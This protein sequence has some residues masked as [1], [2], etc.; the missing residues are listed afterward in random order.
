MEM[1]Y[2][3]RCGDALKA[4]RE[5][6]Y[7]GYLNEVLCFCEKENRWLSDNFNSNERSHKFPRKFYEIFL[8][9]KNFSSF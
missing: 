4:T 2:C 9:M 5:K 8:K 6:N 3:K 1:K 7:L